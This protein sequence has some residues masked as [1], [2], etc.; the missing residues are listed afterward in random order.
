MMD[1][2][3]LE[4]KITKIHDSLVGLMDEFD[5]VIEENSDLDFRALVAATKFILARADHFMKKRNGESS[6]LH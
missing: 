2:A 3:D 6:T 1:I 5:R 4:G